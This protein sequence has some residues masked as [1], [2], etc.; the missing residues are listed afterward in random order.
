MSNDKTPMERFDSLLSR[1]F[2]AGK[3][4]EKPLRLTPRK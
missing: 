1:V 4:N 2:A 3:R